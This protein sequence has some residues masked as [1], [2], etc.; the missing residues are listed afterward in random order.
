MSVNIA[1]SQS[2]LKIQDRGES[3]AYS[4]KNGE[5]A[6]GDSGLFVCVHVTS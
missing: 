3:T 6:V 4:V 2:T 1:E 5:P